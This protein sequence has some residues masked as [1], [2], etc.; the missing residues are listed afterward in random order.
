V[1]GEGLEEGLGE[2]LGEGRNCRIDPCEGIVPNDGIH[3][4]TRP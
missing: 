3:P 4:C 2:G 1:L